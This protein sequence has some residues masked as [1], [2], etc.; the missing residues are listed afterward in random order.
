M[1]NNYSCEIVNRAQAE[2]LSAYLKKLR[3]SYE[4]S[5]CFNGYYFSITATATEAEKINTYIDT[6][7]D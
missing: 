1:R 3:V 2:S 6:L 4:R 5:A 7:A